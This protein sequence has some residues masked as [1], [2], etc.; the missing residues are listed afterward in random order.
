MGTLIG[1][2]PSRVDLPPE[3]KYKLRIEDSTEQTERE[4]ERLEIRREGSL[5]DVVWSKVRITF[6]I[7]FNGY[8]FFFEK[9]KKVNQLNNT[10][11]L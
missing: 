5:V 1:P 7:T 9:Q 8:V 11:A 3:L 2:K 10:T 4:R 6:N